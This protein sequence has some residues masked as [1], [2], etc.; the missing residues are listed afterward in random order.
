[1]IDLS[2]EN[3]IGLA[4]AAK[5]IPP[6][7]NG[8]RCHL[9][10]VLRWVLNGAK[11][12]TGELVKLEASRLGARWVTSREAIQRFML[13]LTPRLDAPPAAAPR[14]SKARS[15]ASARAEQELTRFGI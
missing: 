4:A 3:A 7:R 10:T 1:M 5:L 9:S 12:P 2:G 11:S 6:G 14:T 13:A 15:R 8:K